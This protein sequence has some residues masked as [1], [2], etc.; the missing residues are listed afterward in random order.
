MAMASAMPGNPSGSTRRI[1]RVVLTTTAMIASDDRRPRVLVRVERPGQDGDQGMGDE[2]DEE[3]R[4]GRGGQLDRRRVEAPEQQRHALDGEDRG[5]DRD[6]E[7]H[8]DEEPQGAGQEPHEFAM[9]ADRR[10]RATAT[11]TGRRPAGTPMTPIGIWSRVN[12]MVKAVTAADRRR[13]RQAGHDDE[14]DL[15]RPEAD[16]PRG[17]QGERLPRRRVLEC[18]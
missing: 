12:A 10:P 16:G 11:G 15:R 3:R 6:R 9:V 18:R 4:E 14:G 13:R 1:A 17:H 5:Q 7:H 2:A 8:E